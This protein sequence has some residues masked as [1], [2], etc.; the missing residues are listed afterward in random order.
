MLIDFKPADIH[1]TWVLDDKDRPFGFEFI[2]SA[3]FLE[4]NFGRRDG[5]EMM[6]QVAG[7]QLQRSGFAVCREC[8]SVQS[9]KVMAGKGEPV[10]LKSCSYA[11]G[12]KK[13]VNGGDDFGLDNCLYLYRQFTSEALRIL[14]P[15]LAT[16]GLKSRLTPLLRPC[17]WDSNDGL[18]EKLTICE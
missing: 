11:K 7:E 1:I 18:A 2:R 8:G 10:H 5:E 9:R 15:R 12:V 17:S 14:L 3:T 16:G 4:V 13:L 6:F